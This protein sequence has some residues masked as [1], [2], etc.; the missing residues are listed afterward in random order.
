[1]RQRLAELACRQ[2]FTTTDDYVFANELGD[3]IDDGLVREAFYA[4]IARTGMG[5]RRDQHDRHGNEQMPIRV[6][7]LRH[8][9]CTWAVN[10]WDVTLVQKYAGHRHIQTTMRYVHRVAKTEHADQGGAYLDAV[11]GSAATTGVSL[12]GTS[13]ATE[14]SGA[15]REASIRSLSHGSVASPGSPQST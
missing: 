2:H 3:R 14:G 10:V 6:H 7:D 1:L 13:G 15:F 8:S 9:Y 12:S 4:A 5:H 11:L